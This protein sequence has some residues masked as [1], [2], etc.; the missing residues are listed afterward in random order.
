MKFKSLLKALPI[1]I[2]SM[3]LANA[4][5]AKNTDADVVNTLIDSIVNYSLSA[6]VDS[7]EFNVGADF[8]IYLLDKN[9]NRTL[10]GD[11]KDEL[12]FMTIQ[13]LIE[14]KYIGKIN[15]QKGDGLVSIVRIKKLRA[16]VA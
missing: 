3:F 5:E 2:S 9:G 8:N 1:A 13:S 12:S 11:V 15:Y 6:N 16:L 14:R 10:A 7:I 4:V